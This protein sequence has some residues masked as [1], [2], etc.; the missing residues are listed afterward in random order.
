MAQTGTPG[1]A[2]SPHQDELEGAASGMIE[3]NQTRRQWDQSINRSNR[4][5]RREV[6]ARWIEHGAVF[7][8]S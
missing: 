8:G 3:A 2:M 1:A 4:T 6:T 7:G 5:P